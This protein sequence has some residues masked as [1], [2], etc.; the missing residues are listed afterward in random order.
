MVRKTTDSKCLL[1]TRSLKCPCVVNLRDMS[2]RRRRNLQRFA[3]LAADLAPLVVNLLLRPATSLSLLRKCSSSK[4]AD[5]TS[6][7]LQ[8]A[9]RQRQRVHRDGRQLGR[10]TSSLP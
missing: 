3:L 8:E 10:H 7:K 4:L 1:K 5:L 9:L 2:D 6:V